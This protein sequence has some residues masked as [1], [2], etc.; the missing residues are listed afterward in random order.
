MISH[1]EAIRILL[2]ILL[3][4]CLG[5][6]G[7]IIFEA[8]YGKKIDMVMRVSLVGLCITIL[9]LFQWFYSYGLIL[10]NVR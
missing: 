7:P 2:S 1:T 3:T 8:V 9:I 6:L 4:L 5:I 10:L